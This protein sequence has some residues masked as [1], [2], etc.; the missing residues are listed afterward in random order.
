MEFVLALT[1]ASSRLAPLVASAVASA[2]A[3]AT[4]HLAGQLPDTSA[5]C[6]QDPMH[7]L[8]SEVAAAGTHLR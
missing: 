8:A 6:H 2:I 1:L 5:G 4:G 3:A 7:L